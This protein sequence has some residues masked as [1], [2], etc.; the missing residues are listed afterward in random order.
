MKAPPNDTGAGA[1]QA[2]REPCAGGLTAPSVMIEQVPDRSR[3]RAVSTLLRRHAEADGDKVFLQ[4]VDDGRTLTHAE[5]LA[6]CERFAGYFRSHGI[7][8]GDRL[9]VLSENSLEQAALYF[10][11]LASGVTYC[12]IN[13]E[14]NAAHIAEMT[15]RLAPALIVWGSPEGAIDLGCEAIAMATLFDEAA[16]SPPAPLPE[17]GEEGVAVIAFTSGTTAAPKGMIHNHGNYY[18]IADQVIDMWKLGPVD[19]VLE[20]RSFSWTS[21]HM[22]TLMPALVTGGTVL[23]ARRFSRGRF[24]DWVADYRPTMAIGVPTVVNMLL[25][26]GG[27]PPG[28]GFDG[29]RFMSCSTAPLMVAQHERFEETYGIE[30]V[31]LYG[32]SEGGVVAANHAGERRIG[33]VGPPGLYQNIRI[34]R[35]DGA[36]ADPG[37][38]GEIEIGGAQNASGYLLEGGVVEPIRGTR[39]KTGDLG[40]LDADG[41]LYIAGRAD[42]V[43]IRGGVNIAPL[44]IDA[45]LTRH[46]EISEAAVIGIPDPVYGEA[47][48][49]F[50]APRP[51]TAPAAPDLARHCE[52]H[53]PEFKRPREIMI[54]EDL[55]KNSR[56]KIDRA[57]LRAEWTDAP[58]LRR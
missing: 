45:V 2:V 16:A 37:E 34:L 38:I 6:L 47:V 46:P 13:V 9:L 36:P 50:V 48:V 58:D 44:E 33:S 5:T 15:G 55:P 30:L 53:L 10:A 24:F 41:F 28:K 19:R 12:T 39:L 14:V 7:A 54:R 11:C 18:W 3:Y 29:V 40:Y 26:R 23:F 31:Q 17:I 32:M 4:S 52:K 42:D 51:G 22:L 43:I 21:S 56:G 57:A 8:P 20:Y 49:A 25:D 27:P 35:P 1:A